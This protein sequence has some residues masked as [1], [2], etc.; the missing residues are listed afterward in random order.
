MSLPFG[1][2]KVCAAL[3]DSLRDDNPKG[4]QEDVLERNDASIVE[5]WKASLVPWKDQFKTRL[6][7]GEDRI[8]GDNIRLSH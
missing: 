5:I 2:V 6:G 7:K 8:E 1:V 3:T 4:R